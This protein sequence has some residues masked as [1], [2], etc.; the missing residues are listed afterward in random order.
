MILQVNYL[1]KRLQTHDRLCKIRTHGGYCSCGRDTAMI[2]LTILL[3]AACRVQ[4]SAPDQELSVDEIKRRL[5]PYE[6]EQP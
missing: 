1:L 4:P 2:E 6:P 5:W 3:A